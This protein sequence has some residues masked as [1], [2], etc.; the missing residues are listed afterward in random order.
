MRRSAL[1]VHALSCRFMRSRALVRTTLVMAVTAACLVALFVTLSS[2]TPSGPQAVERDLGRFG[3]AVQL[4]AIEELVVDPGDRKFRRQLAAVARAAAVSTLTVE[5]I[6]LDVRPSGIDAP[7]IYY[8]EAPWR[9]LPFPDRYLLEHGRW[10]TRSGEVVVT[11]AHALD[12]EAGKRLSVFSGRHEFDVVGTARDRY[13]RYPSAL[14]AP[15]TWEALDPSL[16]DAFPTL[17]AS[18]RVLAPAGEVDVLVAELA[19]SLAQRP[20]AQPESALRAALL[21]ATITEPELLN[22][23]DRSWVDRTPAAYSVPFTAFPLLAVLLVFG[24]NDRRL[25]RNLSVLTDLGVR[26]GQAVAA[27]ALAVTV[28]TLIAALAGAVFGIGVAVVIRPI[29]QVWHPL[30]LSPIEGLEGPAARLLAMTVVGAVISAVALSASQRMGRAASGRPRSERSRRWR[31]ARHILAVLAG[32]AAALQVTGLDSA[33][34]AS[35]LAGTL[36]LAVLLLVPETLGWAL[37]VLPE[38]AP[39]PRLAR[40]QLVADRRR[41]V[42]A[43]ATLAAVL[44][45]PIGFLTL[46]DTTFRTLDAEVAPEVLPGQLALSGLGGTLVAPSPAVVGTVRRTLPTADAIQLR[47]LHSNKTFVYVEGTAEGFVLAL[48]TPAE[49]ST[50]LDRRLSMRERA[51]LRRGGM[52][53]WQDS[54]R[55]ES[56]VLIAERPGRKPLATPPLPT[57]R[58]A[59]PAVQWRR[60]ARGIVLSETAAR[61][62]LPIADGARFYTGLTETEVSAARRAVLEAGLDPEQVRVYE[63][64]RSRVP[65]LALYAAATG[66]ALLTLLTCWAVAGGQAATLR[67]YLG[68]LLAVGLSARWARQVVLIQQALILGLATLLAVVIAITPVLLTVWR[69]EGFV[70]GIPWSWLGAVLGSVYLGSCLAILAASRRLRPYARPTA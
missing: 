41:A 47:Y 4:G 9:S 3:A 50:L 49:V 54:A 13:G 67:G 16:L 60:G 6:S 44:G 26:R 56:I 61:L 52:L 12:L 29:L 24:L 28:W 39:R 63:T 69:V 43:S 62:R 58:V 33:A 55:A 38:H 10:P 65:P 22:D 23:P 25:R 37:Q 21:A 34:K 66:M 17:A 5:L 68:T 35:V 7:R 18:A 45:L 51:T 48:D 32:C 15:G 53:A 14:A 64:P 1:F 27:T 8:S 46:L 59:V 70:L 31:D 20:G 19:R 42:V 30:P 11:N 57:V 40:R 2:L 36:A